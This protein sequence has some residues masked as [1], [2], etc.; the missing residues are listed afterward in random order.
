M[1]SS[2]SRFLLNSVYM[3]WYQGINKSPSWASISRYFSRFSYAIIMNICK[4]LLSLRIGSQQPHVG[5]SSYPSGRNISDWLLWG[6]IPCAY[7]RVIVP[8]TITASVHKFGGCGYDIAPVLRPILRLGLS[9]LFI[10]NST[11]WHPSGLSYPV[12]YILIKHLLNI[13]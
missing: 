4:C 8:W 13:H 3:Y 11:F 10:Q 2:V 9:T 1:G 6:I 7:L 12:S 5:S